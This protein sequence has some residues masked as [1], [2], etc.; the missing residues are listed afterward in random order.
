M[1]RFVPLPVI[2]LLAFARMAP[3]APAT[4]AAGGFELREWA[5]FILDASQNTLNPDGLVT[6]T[7]PSFV[8]TRRDASN[9][10]SHD[11]SPVGVI[12]LIGDSEKPVDITIEASAGSFLSSWPPADKR[13]KQLLWRNTK[14]TAASPTGQAVE[15]VPDGHWFQS[16]RNVESGYLSLERGPAE[17]FLLYD[18]EMPC[19]SPLTVEVGKDHSIRVAN[20]SHAALHRLTFY[21]PIDASWRQ[22][23]VGDLAAAAAAPATRP[24]TSPAA[25]P[26]SVFADS[27][28]TAPA[29][30]MPSTLPSTQPAHLTAVTMAPATRLS[31]LTDPW[32]PVLQKLGVAEADSGVMLSILANTLRDSHKLAAVYL[33]D[34]AEFDRLLPLEV[35]P[36]P[37]TIRRV[38]MVIVRNT[39]PSAGSDVDDLIAQLA[40]P[41]WSRRPQASHRG[42]IQGCRSSMARGKTPGDI[43]RWQARRGKLNSGV[44]K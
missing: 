3:A 34:D 29:S 32:K 7:L 26:A 4:Q 13:S 15:A 16:L 11:A 8:T 28:A 44:V 12:R 10:P 31:D 41:A 42:K 1:V 18:V 30:T 6:S 35:V 5:V 19:P 9:P 23:T 20:S 33:M 40:D 38:G 39:D 24:S 21:Q 43:E 37:R 25:V 36:E 2:L 17:R 27:P 14:L 22:G